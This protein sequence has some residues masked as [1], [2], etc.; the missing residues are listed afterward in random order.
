MCVRAH[1]SGDDGG[2]G[3]GGGWSG[4]QHE[5]K[6]QIRHRY[7]SLGILKSSATD[8]VCMAVATIHHLTLLE[9]LAQ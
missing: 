4:G 3:G 6:T 7:K 8:K 2:G 1:T 9:V 5:N